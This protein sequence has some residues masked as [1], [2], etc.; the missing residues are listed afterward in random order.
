M[1]NK[2]VI[3]IKN[4]LQSEDTMCMVDCLRALGF[5][6]KIDKKKKE[7]VIC[8]YQKKEQGTM[9]VGNSGLTARFIVPLC[10]HLPGTW[11]INCHPRMS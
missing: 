7:A 5:D 6:V 4:F 10:A 3:T 8:G 2:D 9:N 11:T 1:L